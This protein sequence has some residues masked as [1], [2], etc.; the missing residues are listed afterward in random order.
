MAWARLGFVGFLLSTLDL[1]KFI[2]ITS[3]LFWVIAGSS[4]F[5]AV[6]AEEMQMFVLWIECHLNP[7]TLVTNRLPMLRDGMGS[8]MQTDVMFIQCV[9]RVVY[10][11]R[12][13][14]LTINHQTYL[15]VARNT[16][17]HGSV[18]LYSASKNKCQNMPE[19]SICSNVLTTTQVWG[20]SVLLYLSL[21][22]TILI[23]AYWQLNLSLHNICNVFSYIYSNG[24]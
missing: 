1:I 5:A 8:F 12:I 22:A 7:S 21:V 4:K 15:M 17:M 2:A 6:H 19:W 3:F 23:A 10:V 20:C 11:C 16:G 13:A 18:H 24:L 14:Y 9:F